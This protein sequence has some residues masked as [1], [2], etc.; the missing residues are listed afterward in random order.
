MVSLAELLATT[1]SIVGEK[2]PASDKAAEDSYNLL[3]AMLG[4][5]NPIKRDFLIIQCGNGH[6][7]VRSGPWKFIPDVALADGWQSVKKDMSGPA[8]PGIY[9]LS[10]D[11][12]EKENLFSSSPAVAKRLAGF[13]AEAQST[14]VT[15]P[16]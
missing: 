1:S 7:S 14:P 11:P 16:Q 3:P 4:E 9:D 6:L 2:L 10:K 5:A 15:R 13:L 12:G 8:R